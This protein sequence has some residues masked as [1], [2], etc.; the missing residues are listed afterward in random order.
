[1]Y[2][3]K[4]FQKRKKELSHAKDLRLEKAEAMDELT[5]GYLEWWRQ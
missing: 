1:M 2:E 4:H 5:A 3:E